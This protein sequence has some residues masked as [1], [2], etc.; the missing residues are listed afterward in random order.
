VLQRVASPVVAVLLALFITTSFVGPE[1]TPRP[2][3]TPDF[4]PWIDTSDRDEVIAA[5]RA[6]FDREAPPMNWTGEA[7][8][9]DPGDSSD[10]L[11]RETLIRIA[12][13]RAMAGVP[14][15]VIEDPLMS[16]KAQA[17]ALMMSVEGE[18][19]HHPDSDYACFSAAGQEAAANSNLYLGRTGPLA[20]D[21][22]IEDPGDRNVDVGHRSTILHPPTE[23]MGIGHVS[24]TLDRYPANA[25]WV[26]DRGVFE[27]EYET[28]EPA[29]FVA[30]PPRGHVPA[31]VVYPRWSFGLQ[32]AS[33]ERAT[34]TMTGPDGLEVPLEIVAR[35]SKD[36]EI[37]SSVIVWE[38]KLEFGEPEGDQIFTVTVADVGPPED[39]LSSQVVEIGDT[40]RLSVPAEESTYT[41]EV[42]V[43]DQSEES[44][45]VRDLLS[46]V[47]TTTGELLGVM[48][49]GG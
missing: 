29:G 18:L 34:V 36:G 21:G 22:Y 38:P 32:R 14:A 42:V 37:P 10:A 43:V 17:A 5:F 40:G 12:Y 24:G 2:K 26:F 49:F 20:I 8:Q 39:R 30:W 45:P 35:L 33:F 47:S 16:D 23:V 44:G 11:R 25:L 46:F 19:T 31:E 9:C 1:A 48:S 41:Y 28:R 7:G 13:Y 6:A 4:A 15:T 3:P 27:L